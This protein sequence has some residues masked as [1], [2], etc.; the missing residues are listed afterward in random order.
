[1]TEGEKTINAIYCLSHRL[2]LRKIHLPRQ[3]EARKTLITVYAIL[4]RT[5]LRM[6]YY[7]FS[8]GFVHKWDSRKISR[9]PARNEVTQHPLDSDTC[10]V[11][12]AEHTA[13]GT[14]LCIE[15]RPCICSFFYCLSICFTQSSADNM[16]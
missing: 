6:T 1:M 13:Q 10:A 11:S 7:H 14:E 2:L 16:Q 3:R 9:S 4:R 15:V 12:L 5:L 8:G